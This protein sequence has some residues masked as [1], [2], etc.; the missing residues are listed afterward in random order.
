MFCL[1]YFINLMSK[2]NLS[3]LFL[4]ERRDVM[5]YSVLRVV[6]RGEEHL[7][8]CKIKISYRQRCWG[9]EWMK[10]LYA[11]VDISDRYQSK[12]SNGCLLTHMSWFH[13][14]ILGQQSWCSYPHIKS[15]AGVKIYSMI[16]VESLHF[17]QLRFL[18][19]PVI[20]PF[21]QFDVSC[22]G[23]VRICRSYCYL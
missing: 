20:K 8:K 23:C 7:K 3:V 5:N 14:L 16:D 1:T 9:R 4:F 21:F 6:N 17:E 11:Y 12:F 19:L 10:W 22:R 18:L 2:Y 15:P 13:L